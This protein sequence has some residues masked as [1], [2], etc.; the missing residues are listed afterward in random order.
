MKTGT[1]A[2]LAQGLRSKSL[3][4]VE[5]TQT[6]LDRIDRQNSA[7][8]AF[9]TVD[10][11][12]RARGGEGGRRAHRLRRRG[13]AHGHPD[14]AQGRADDRGPS[15]HVRLADARK[16]RRAVR[17]VRRR[18]TEACRHG[19]RSARPTWTSSRWARRTRPRTSARSG[20][21]GTPTTS[22][23]AAPAGRRPRSRRGSSPGAT[24]TDTGGSIRQPASLSGICGLKPTY[25]VCS[26]YGLVAFASSLDQAGRVRADRRGLRAAA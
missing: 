14:R 2:D 22:P 5:L 24:G 18:R 13:A 23:A 25:G 20:I 17:R 7:L 16:L 4:S 8:N 1:I 26:R 10:R 12:G 9:V 11:R 19:A 6:M 15:H 3:S 21:R